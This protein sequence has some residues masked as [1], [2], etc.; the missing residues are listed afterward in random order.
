MNMEKNQLQ[1]QIREYIDEMIFGGNP[2]QTFTNDTPLISNRIMDS[3][4]TLKLIAH[5]EEKLG[6]EFRAHEVTAEN[7][8]TV[9]I[10]AD[11]LLRKLSR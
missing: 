10:I 8:D 11:F 6:V 5:F 4:V 3:I 9:N 7:L 1:K 2:P